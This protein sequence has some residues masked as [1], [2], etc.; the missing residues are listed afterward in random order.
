MRLSPENIIGKS[1][2]PGKKFED[3]SEK[4]E[5]AEYAAN[6]TESGS[7]YNKIKIAE[8]QSAVHPDNM[9][10]SVEEEEK[11]DQT[12]KSFIKAEDAV[13]A[14]NAED[15]LIDSI[16]ANIAAGR[17][18]NTEKTEKDDYGVV[19]IANTLIEAA[20]DKG[21]KKE[22]ENIVRR[23]NSFTTEYQ[24]LLTQKLPAEQ[25][26]KIVNALFK[27][28]FGSLVYTD[29]RM[30]L[31]NLEDS[32]VKNASKNRWR[33]QK[34]SQEKA[35]TKAKITLKQPSGFILKKKEALAP[36]LGIKKSENKWPGTNIFR[37]IKINW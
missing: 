31:F 7:D 28:H 25:E 24:T 26:A 21:D 8:S 37:K 36:Q 2:Y 11:M 13:D 19:E 10:N 16:D 32:L 18:M 27:T 12:E 5:K 23:M 4:K 17:E 30:E 34:N 6:N 20:K 9:Y 29:G 33:G 22:V 3:L 14:N 15:Y 1:S 35:E